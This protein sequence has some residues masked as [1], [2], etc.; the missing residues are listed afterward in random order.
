MHSVAQEDSLEKMAS[1]F[2]LRLHHVA[3]TESGNFE[4]IVL[5][6]DPFLTKLHPLFEGY[7]TQTTTATT[8]LV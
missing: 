1:K 3:V 2:D 4:S 5:G 7:C 8:I 6:F